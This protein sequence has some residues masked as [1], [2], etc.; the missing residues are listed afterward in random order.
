MQGIEYKFYAARNPEFF[1]DAEEI[2]LD[3]VL[4]QSEFIRDVAVGKAIGNQRYHLFFPAGKQDL[5]GS[6]HH[7]HAWQLTHWSRADNSVVGWW[8][9]FLLD[10]PARCNRKIAGTTNSPNRTAHVPRSERLARRLGKLSVSKRQTFGIW[11]CM[12][13][14]ACES[15]PNP[16]APEFGDAQL[17][18]TFRPHFRPQ[19]KIPKWEELRLGNRS[20]QTRDD[21]ANRPIA[22]FPAV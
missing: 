7:A 16:V 5:P 4:A 19:N 3:R 8:R 22:G 2:F 1:E 18:T 15:S 21:E 6:A 20:P 12:R 17:I 9:R 14:E 10:A 13:V 11:G